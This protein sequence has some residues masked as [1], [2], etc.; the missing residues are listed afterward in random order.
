MAFMD[1]RRTLIQMK[2]PIQ[3][4]NMGAEAP[5]KLLIKLLDNSAE[6]IRGNR[7]PHRAD[8]VDTLLRAGL[9]VFQEVL[10]GPVAFRVTVF[11]F[12]AF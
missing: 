5:F 10:Y 8:L 3:N 12:R 1:M 11:S 4:V 9:V 6:G 2:C 7:L